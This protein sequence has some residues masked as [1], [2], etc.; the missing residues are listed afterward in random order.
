MRFIVTGLFALHLFFLKNTIP[1][2]KK[3]LIIM[4]IESNYY[5]KIS[6]EAR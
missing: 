3:C 6:G 4:T 2:I 1:K 5:D